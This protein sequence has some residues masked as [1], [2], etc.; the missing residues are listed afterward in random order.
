MR[1]IA[2][3]TP[4]FGPK[5]CIYTVFCK[6]FTTF[7]SLAGFLSTPTSIFAHLHLNVLLLCT[8][9]LIEKCHTVQSGMVAH[10]NAMHELKI[11]SNNSPINTHNICLL[12][13]CH[14]LVKTLHPLPSLD[15]QTSHI[16]KIKVRLLVQYLFGWNIALCINSIL[17]IP[18][19]ETLTSRIFIFTQSFNSNTACCTFKRLQQTTV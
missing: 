11:L 6:V 5:R 2:N 10:K 16:N 4:Y 19:F 7:L 8:R 12:S 3:C 17:G 13:C 9:D 15:P 1:F 18:Q 14:F